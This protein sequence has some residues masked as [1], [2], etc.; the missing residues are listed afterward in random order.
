MRVDNRTGKGMSSMDK[1]SSKFTVAFRRLLCLT[2]ANT[3]HYT[4]SNYP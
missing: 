4:H 2:T 3:N 1:F